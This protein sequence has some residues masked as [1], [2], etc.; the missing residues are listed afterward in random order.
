[1]L[2][3]FTSAG[4]L[5]FFYYRFSKPYTSFFSFPS[6][7]LF[8]LLFSLLTLSPFFFFSSYVHILSYRRCDPLPNSFN[9]PLKPIGHGVSTR[10]SQRI[11]G[12]RNKNIPAAARESPS[13]PKILMEK[14]LSHTH[15][16]QAKFFGAFLSS[17][18]SCGGG[19]K[20]NAQ[21]R[22]NPRHRMKQEIE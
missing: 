15:S 2:T 5:C 7:P 13:S 6:A 3:S 17:S 21:P 19:Q 20:K 12:K 8:L 18:S 22:A 11:P 14:T 9:Y 16:H 1:M 10:R 4:S